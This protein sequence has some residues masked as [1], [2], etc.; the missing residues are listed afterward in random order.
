M[1]GRNWSRRNNANDPINGRDHLTGLYTLQAFALRAQDIIAHAGSERPAWAVLFL[2]IHDFRRYNRIYGYAEGDRLLQKFAAAA[3]DSIGDD[4]ICRVAEDHFVIL[5]QAREA[6]HI[7]QV[8]QEKLHEAS[9]DPS[10]LFRGGIYVMQNGDDVLESVDKAQAA[11]YS[12]RSDETDRP[13]ICWFNRQL[14]QELERN[15]YISDYIEEAIR[16]GH[17]E[18]YYQPVMRT[19]T[20][21]LCGAEVLSRWN[22]PAYG[23]M[24]PE[25]YIH[26]LEESHQIHL[27]DL[28]IVRRICSDYRREEDAGRPFPPVS[29]N[30]SRLDFELCDIFHEIDQIVEEYEMPKDML[31]VELTESFLAE[32]TDNMRI[33]MRRFQEAGYQIWMDDFGSGYS[34]LNVLK[35]FGYDAIKIDME[36]LREFGP[37]A[38]KIV[39]SIVDMAK[40]LGIQTIAEGVE[41]E[42]QLSFLRDIGCEKIQGYFYGKPQSFEQG[43]GQILSDEERTEPLRLRLYYDRVGREN[44]IDDRP[45]VLSEYVDEHFSAVYYNAAMIDLLERF[46]IRSKRMIGDM[47][48]AYPRGELMSLRNAAVG[49]GPEDGWRAVSMVAKD[50]YLIFRMK[51][52]A[53]AGTR[54]MFLCR[55]IGHEEMRDIHQTQ[56]MDTILRALYNS[57][58]EVY[59]TDPEAGTVRTAVLRGEEQDPSEEEGITDQINTFVESRIYPE[60]AERY[61]RFT[62]E[63]TLYDRLMKNPKSL[64]TGFFRTKDPDGRYR[65]KL[66]AMMLRDRAGGRA[67]IT[68]IM[69]V[70]EA[71]LREITPIFSKILEDKGSDWR[72]LDAGR[73][74]QGLPEIFTDPEVI[75][76]NAEFTNPEEQWT[77]LMVY[78]DLKLFWKDRDRRYV[79]ATRA[80]LEFC[81]FSSIREIIGKT[82]EEIKWDVDIGLSVENEKYVLNTGNAVWMEPSQRFVRS[83]LHNIAI[84]RF[85]MYRD[86]QIIGLMGYILD[87]SDIE[88]SGDNWINS[89]DTS[90]GSLNYGGIMA[91]ANRYLE[92]LSPVNADFAMVCVNIHGLHHYREKFGADYMD[93]LM[94]IIFEHLRD[95]L[96]GLGTIGRLRDNQFLVLCRFSPEEMSDFC[97]RVHEEMAD[98][99]DFS[100]RQTAVYHSIGAA[101]YSETKDLEK[102]V[103]LARERSEKTGEENK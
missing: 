92:T 27:L 55:T 76:A 25:Q 94:R 101:W 24:M 45:I 69:G 78:S 73:Y 1:F 58:D 74:A 49:L 100:G 39:T 65:W 63:D 9:M 99:R 21:R 40:K 36:F 81:N 32:M 31:R 22:S 90:S 93:R 50:Q 61:R 8:V 7:L 96:S 80:F 41:T 13:A 15:R 20:G 79:G 23:R 6:E 66:H 87:L 3:K 82:L 86:G 33:S 44:L 43:I 62:E 5:M 38:Q 77:N 11:A 95:A 48:G 42:E 103:S 29:F 28:A 88:D 75:R 34:S 97:R 14:K 102:C 59:I 68:V 54:R 57:C 71:N 10:L 46:D 17:I 72:R 52:I 83:R 64:Q 60:D 18:A 35:N 51:C 47:F 16:L 91:A 12:L 67:F 26:V 98:L 70:D 53:Q 37:R 30:L 4:I 84:N 2:N 85:P 19:L 56:E 89:I